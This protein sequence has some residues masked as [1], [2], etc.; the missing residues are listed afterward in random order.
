[1]VSYAG[2]LKDTNENLLTTN[3]LNVRHFSDDMVQGY[4]CGQSHFS[5]LTSA[6]A[7]LKISE[8]SSI[9]YT[10]GVKD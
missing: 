8:A 1:M 9:S 4:Q 2:H 3:Y 10:A 6:K 5:R 7:T